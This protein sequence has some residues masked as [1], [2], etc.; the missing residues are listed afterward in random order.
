M[1]QSFVLKWLFTSSNKITYDERKIVGIGA[2][3][4]PW[5]EICSLLCHSHETCFIL[6]LQ[7]IVITGV[8]VSCCS[9]VVVDDNW[10]Q[11]NQAKLQNKGRDIKKEQWLQ[12]NKKRRNSSSKTTCKTM[13]HVIRF[14]HRLRN[15][16]C[17]LFRLYRYLFSRKTPI[18][19]DRGCLCQLLGS[20]DFRRY[21]NRGHVPLYDVLS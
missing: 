1:L 4:L 16:F 2:P 14:S 6:S 13:W 15:S 9:D 17:T 11:C 18:I 21:L 10:W 3:Y 12:E 8:C 7:L 5:D 19:K 20:T